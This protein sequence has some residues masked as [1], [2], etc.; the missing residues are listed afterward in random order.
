MIMT[1]SAAPAVH[2]TVIRLDRG[3]ALFSDL[4]STVW[5]VH[6]STVSQMPLNLGAL[7]CRTLIRTATGAAYC[8]ADDPGQKTAQ[9]FLQ[10][11]PIGPKWRNIGSPALAAALRG[12]AMIGDGFLFFTNKGTVSYYDPVVGFCPYRSIAPLSYGIDWGVAVDADHVAVA[13]IGSSKDNG[14][15]WLTLSW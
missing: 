12:V 9:A 2:Q 3:Q 4:S 6:D 15:L 1:S 5:Y 7:T 10:F 8:A 11:D 13:S 14:V